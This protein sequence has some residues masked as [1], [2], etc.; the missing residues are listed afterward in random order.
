MTWNW[1]NE[2]WTNLKQALKL[3]IK[4]HE[5][6]LNMK[7]KWVDSSE[8]K[9]RLEELDSD[10]SNGI[11]NVGDRAALIKLLR[12]MMHNTFEIYLIFTTTKFHWVSRIHFEK[13][14]VNIEHVMAGILEKIEQL[15][16]IR[17]TLDIT[18]L[19][20]DFAQEYTLWDPPDQSTL[21][22]NE[23][24][25]TVQACLNSLSNIYKYNT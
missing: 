13:E 5:F 11:K 19:K 15:W 4:Q 22:P 21:T 14:Y 24:G 6:G 17:Q 20:A 9:R 12:N 23:P 2:S 8:V 10:M 25:Q 1:T 16:D 18:Q 3:F 7:D